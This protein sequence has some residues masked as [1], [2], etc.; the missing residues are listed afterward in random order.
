MRTLRSFGVLAGALAAMLLSAGVASAHVTV[1]PKESAPGAFETYV[2]SVPSER[3]SAT[4]RVELDIPD[5]VLFSKVAP[6]PG[7]QYELVRNASGK[8]TGINW[9]GGSIGPDEFDQFAF[10]AR[11]PREVG[12]VAWKARQTYADGN[13]VQWTGP[14]GADTPASVTTIKAGATANDSHAD[15]GVT[16]APAATA[17]PAAASHG[18]AVSTT[19]T[20]ATT[21]DG[22]ALGVAG[23]GFLTGAVALILAV[24]ALRRGA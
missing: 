22:M 3:P 10:Q 20:T 6:K 18:P 23:A 8:V 21:S 16:P 11:N 15:A 12:S 4:T 2:V 13:V 1:Q 14:V 7:W 5:T 9:A 17:A 19:A 24:V